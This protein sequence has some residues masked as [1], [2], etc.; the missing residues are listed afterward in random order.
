MEQYSWSYD[1]H[2]HIVFDYS[3]AGLQAR[4]KSS[5]VPWLIFRVVIQTTY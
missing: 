3:E 2:G 5:Y 1:A 4:R